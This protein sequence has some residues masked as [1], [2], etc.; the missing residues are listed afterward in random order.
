MK[1]LF[2]AH[3]FGQKSEQALLRALRLADD[4]AALRV[5]HCSL[6]PESSA[7]RAPKR[8][9]LLNEAQIMAEE[10]GRQFLDIS[11]VVASGDPPELIVREADAF[12][13]DLI[14]MGG[15][16]EPRFRDAVFGTTAT[17]VIR[18]SHR[19]VLIVQDVG[20]AAYPEMM[21]AVDDPL[22]AE[23]LLETALAVAPTAGITAIHAYSPTLVQTFVGTKEL[24][25]QEKRIQRQISEAFLEAGG[26]ADID[27]RVETGEVLSVLMCAHET[28]QPDLLVM[29]TRARATYLGSRAVD[30]LFWC[31]GD[32]L[33]VPEHVKKVDSTLPAQPVSAP[34]N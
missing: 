2:V 32:L 17:H 16:G 28:R 8:T 25:Q 7:E 12:E 6:D 1:R 3:D 20:L 26:P 33:V 4:D 19:P 23:Y 21:I 18:H 9:R 31:P 34:G 29:G 14:L 22:D 5:F 30:T 24:E 13:A 11:A 15:H 27:V 10:V